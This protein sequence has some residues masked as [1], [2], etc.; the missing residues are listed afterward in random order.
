MVRVW[1]NYPRPSCPILVTRCS[2]TP[3]KRWRVGKSLSAKRQPTSSTIVGPPVS[4]GV[5][6]LQELFPDGGAGKGSPV[7]K[8]FRRSAP[9][10]E[11]D[12]ASAPACWTRDIRRVQIRDQLDECGEG[13]SE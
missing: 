2:S 1:Q 10:V 3:S 9:N 8:P 13:H 4:P 11:S 5:S 7:P 6:A 12:A